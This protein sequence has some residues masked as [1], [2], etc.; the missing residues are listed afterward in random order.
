M[1]S[2]C[3]I[4]K[5]VLQG[6]CL[7]LLFTCSGAPT[8]APV[9]TTLPVNN[10]HSVVDTVSETKPVQTG[11]TN[12][13][14]DSL[15][16]Y[17]DHPV[18]FYALK[19]Q[20]E[21]MHSGG[22][23]DLPDKYFHI[24]NDPEAILY[25]YWAVAFRK[26]EYPD[27]YSLSFATWKPWKTKLQRSYESDNETLVGIRCCVEWDELGPSNFVGMSIDSI[28]ARFGE[29]HYRTQTTYTYFQDDQLLVLEAYPEKVKWFK[30][31]WWHEPVVIDS[32][33]QAVFSWTG[34]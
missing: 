31:Y 26:P 28:K 7:T 2:F 14:A 15:L 16:A 1:H 30:Y 27:M 9:E 22:K 21:H 10:Q 29:P 20:T 18:D 8:T 25:N 19:K 32:L 24:V 17:F 11:P 13:T 33:P 5:F 23:M 4:R 6:A 34:R 3:S 12:P